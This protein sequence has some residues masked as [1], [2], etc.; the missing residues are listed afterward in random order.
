MKKFYVLIVA[1]FVLFAQVFA[2]D[3]T[4]V[5]GA[6]GN[7]NVA[8]NWTP[9]GVPD[10]VGENAI[11]NSGAVVT[12][13]AGDI[14]LNSLKITGSGNDVTIISPNGNT[15]SITV[16]NSSPLTGALN[17][18]AGS[19]LRLNAGT[20]S[21]MYLIM[22]ENS[23]GI[24]DGTLYLDGANEDDI[25]VFL[26]PGTSSTSTQVNISNTGT[27]VSKKNGNSIAADIDGFLNFNAGSTLRLEDNIPIIP[28]A[29]YSQ[30]SNIYVTGLIN[31]DLTID[32]TVSIGNLTFDCPGLSS[33][34][35]LNIPHNLT[36]AGDINVL[37]TNGQQLILMS[38]RQ[39]V[40]NQTQWSIN[41]EG[42]LK[43]SNNSKVVLAWPN[44]TNQQFTATVRNISA[45]GQSFVLQGNNNNALPPTTLIVK[46]NIAHTNGTF[47]AGSTAVNNSS[48]LFII[49]M[50]GSGTQT[51]N[52]SA[53]SFDNAGN[54]V[55]LK[56]NKPTS[57][58][59]VNLLSPLSVGRLN[60]TSGI[61]H[62]TSTNYLTIRNTGEQP[63][64][65]SSTAN[66]FVEG[67]LRRMVATTNEVTFATGSGTVKRSIT[68]KPSSNT[69]TTFEAEYV[70]SSNGSTS[71]AA[72]L[73][74]IEQNYYWKVNR[75]SGSANAKIK[76]TLT[77]AIAGA[78][79]GDAIVV[80]KF[81]SPNWVRARGTDGTYIIG[82]QTSGDAISEEQ[83][84]FG[85][86]TFG[87]GVQASVLPIK[88]ESF[89]AKQVNSAAQLN[90]R[91]SE[92]SN[93][94]SFEVMKSGDGINFSK[95]G[96]VTALDG[97]FSY[98][99][100][101]NSLLAGNNYYRLRMLDK[102]GVVSFSNIIAIMNGTKGVMISSMIPTMVIDRARLSITSSIKGNMQLV[103]TDISGRVIQ[104][105]N[106]SI[107][108]GNQEIWLNASRLSPGIYQVTGYINGEKTETTRFF[109]R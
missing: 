26:I 95:I 9:N 53:G 107:T 70:N 90:W 66:S 45:G 81:A 30:S 16:F 106:A 35:T 82:D 78:D 22:G 52:S 4:W 23:R 60:L 80:A 44:T 56:I 103:V 75:T 79:G 99:F 102:D 7:W 46:G 29:T 51:I 34:A 77:N 40:S 21:S 1:C 3:Y 96:T 101:D 37:N 97:K 33:L 62:T 109:K 64:V 54:Q 38:N 89:T 14:E 43:I 73:E 2:Q 8:A 86:Y 87:Y 83:T 84:G 47:S 41:I 61:L 10:A 74:G 50:S 98:D 69:A 12:F 20:A 17:I 91:I 100:T 72:P 6:S 68:I 92:N 76:L 32:E 65:L 108:A 49:E 59:L 19:T 58:G 27:I 71:F 63:I 24:I 15:Q 25:G 18:S 104:M 88:L 93:A 13:D 42:D 11:F 36:V 5:G 57:T 94:V 67:P 39:A 28:W 48:D 105:Q 31:S 85:S 55:T